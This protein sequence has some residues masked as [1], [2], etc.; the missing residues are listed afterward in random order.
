MLQRIF[1]GFPRVFR[2]NNLVASCLQITFHGNRGRSRFCSCS[3]ASKFIRRDLFNRIVIWKI[4]KLNIFAWKPI[5]TAWRCSE[6]ISAFSKAELHV[7]TNQ[8]SHFGNCGRLSWMCS[9]LNNLRTF[10]SWGEPCFI[11]STPYSGTLV[12]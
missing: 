12:N 2:L 8:W 1:L 7:D 11:C 4:L 5:M 3:C 10:H 9:P 6:A